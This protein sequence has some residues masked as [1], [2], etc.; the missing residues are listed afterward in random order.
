MRSLF[1]IVM[2]L[3]LGLPVCGQT[4]EGKIVYHYTFK[5]KLPKINDDQLTLLMGSRQEYFIK[6]GNYKT[7]SNGTSFLWQIYINKEN[8]LYNKLSHS[9]A[10]LW[11]DGGTVDNPLTDVVH[12]KGAVEILGYECDELILRSK[13]QTES[14]YFNAK[15]G[16]DAALYSKHLLG[17]WYDYLK[18]AKALP[19]KIIIDNQQFTATGTAT[20]IKAVKLIDKD[21]QI[22]PNVKT[23]KAIS[24]GGD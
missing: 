23:E 10:I 19:L 5:S 20:E 9:Q 16:V 12:N 14:Y 1:S 11:Y 4:F 24:A 17:H 22:P 18:V 6:G 8:R 2:I 13:N 15:F 21:F 3:L 7:V